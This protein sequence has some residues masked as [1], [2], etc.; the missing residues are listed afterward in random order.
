MKKI[1]ETQG[2]NT[3]DKQEDEVYIRN[4]QGELIKLEMV[5]DDEC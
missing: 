3:P 1:F 2:P 4:D 5:G